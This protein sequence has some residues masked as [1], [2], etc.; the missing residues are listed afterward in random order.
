LIHI[1]E[2]SWTRH[3]K[4]PSKILSVGETI[5]AVVLKVDRDHQ[6][7]SLGLKQVEPDPWSLIEQKYPV[8][9]RILGKVRNLT[10][11]GAF[12]E[13]E[14]GIDGLLHISDMSWAKR[15]R[16][17]SEMLKKGDELEVVV[18]DISQ[19]KK[20]ISLGMK[21]LQENPW[22]SLASEFAVDTV[23]EGRV[24]RILDR[25]AVVELRSDV[26]GFVPVGQMGKP[27]LRHPDDAFAV[28]DVLPLKVIK[29]D[30]KNKRIVLSVGAY[31][32]GVSDEELNEF[33]ARFPIRERPTE[34]AVGAPDSA[35]L[36]AEQAPAGADSHVSGPS[37]P[38]AP[39]AVE[40]GESSLPRS[41]EAGD[42]RSG[43]AGDNDSDDDLPDDDSHEGGDAGEER[44]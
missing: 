5:E 13:I 32:K 19:E 7:I 31:L 25:G 4:H 35:R 33:H 36:E 34:P 1:S 30:P 41:L 26:E 39:G 23:T 42:A 17:P 43:E 44:A 11:F 18:L 38:D 16:H 22:E 10:N 9:T 37:E 6:K 3:V 2:M 14:E 24:T 28:D 29:V 21:Q 15:V 8:G 27:D 20:R 40:S 12:V